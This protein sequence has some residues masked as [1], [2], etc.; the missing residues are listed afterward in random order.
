MGIAELNRQDDLNLG[1][2]EIF[3]QYSLGSKEDGWVYYL[4]IRRRR[5]K[6]IKYTPDK[7]LNNDDFFSVSGNFEDHQ[8]QIPGRHSAHLASLYSYP[9]LNTLRAALRVEERSWAKL[10]NFEPTYRYSSRRKARVTDFLLEDAPEPDPTLPQINLVLLIAE[11]EMAKRSKVRAL[12]TETNRPKVPQTGQ[13]T[14]TVVALPSQQPSSS[15]ANKRA[16]TSQTEQRL[17]DEDETILPPSPQPSPQPEYSD[18]ADSSK[19]APSL[20]FQ[21]R[22]IQETDSVVAEKDHLMAFNLA[23]SVCL[24]KDMEHHNKQLNTE[25]KAIQSSTKSMIL[26]IQKNNIAHKKVLELRKTT[27]Q[28]MA[29]AEAKTAELEQAKKQIAELQSENGRLTGLVSSAEAEKQKIA[30]TVKDKY[31]REL[32][33]LEGKKKAEIAEL[34][35]KLEGAESRGFK[36]GEALYIQQCEAAKDLFFKCGWRGAVEQLGSGPDT[37]VY[38]APQYFIPDSLAE[39]AADLQKQF[40]EESDDEENE[41]TETSAVNEQTNDQSARLE[42]TAEDFATETV[43]P[44]ETGLQIETTLTSDTG[45]PIDVD[46]DLENLFN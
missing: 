40:L 45:V 43:L 15:R 35:K 26:A 30:A 33:K 39:Y 13:T 8:A 4:R 46:A 28:A 5:D 23:K 14:E 19:W 44:I 32:A 10:L 3:H 2:A 24:P 20:T 42:L 12:L 37:E 29:D 31:L 36:E 22:D 6:I 38:N 21:N 7:D 34:E 11:Q 17:V 9:N 16:R 41:Q 1:L 27:R 25:L 18:R